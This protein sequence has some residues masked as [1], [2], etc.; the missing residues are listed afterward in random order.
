VVPRILG[1]VV[2]RMGDIVMDGSL[3]RRLASLRS[4]ML[5]SAA[6]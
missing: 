2:V 3:A 4:Q 5:G 1:G 6:R